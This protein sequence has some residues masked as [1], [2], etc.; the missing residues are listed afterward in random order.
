MAR[1]PSCEYPLPDDRERLGAR[2]PQCRDPLYEPPGRVS[3]PARPQEGACAVHDG[4]ESVGTCDRCGNYLCEVCRTPWRGGVVCAA[5]AERALEAGEAAPEQTRAHT[6]QATLALV[7][8][9][10]TWVLG[11]LFIFVI[12]L[13]GA[14]N[15]APLVLLGVL[16][17]AGDTIVA[18]LGMGQAIAA[19]RLRGPHMILATAGMVLCGLYLGAL[20]GLFSFS[21]WAA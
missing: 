11:V 19:L 10:G 3:R 16:A 4:R 7:L 21:Y 1:C 2:C 20:I 9:I 17:L 14:S 6:R 12:A 18:A 13:G 5:C 15:Q 8:G